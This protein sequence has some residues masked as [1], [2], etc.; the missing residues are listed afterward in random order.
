[1]L[2]ARLRE[3]TELASAG[4]RAPLRMEDGLLSV[5][6]GGR[7]ISGLCRGGGIIVVL[8]LLLP[9]E[10]CMGPPKV[11]AAVVEDAGLGSL[12]GDEGTPMLRLEDDSPSVVVVE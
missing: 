7:L 2:A 10:I 9:W 12:E 4:V 5:V 8:P 11:E 6:S 3:E 1:M